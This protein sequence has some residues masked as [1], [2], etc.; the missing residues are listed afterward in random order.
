MN[1]C[2]VLLFQKTVQS[3]NGAGITTLHE[4]DPEDN[5]TGIRIA[6]A[7]IHNKLDFG[8]CML[9]RVLIGLRERSRRDSMEPL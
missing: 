7:H 2:Q 5:K 6:T 8:R 4:L 1:S 3:G 9:V